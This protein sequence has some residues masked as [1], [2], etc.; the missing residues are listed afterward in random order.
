MH[1]VP[2]THDRAP[3]RA[4]DSLL[5]GPAGKLTTIDPIIDIWSSE[6]E[7]FNANMTLSHD[8]R[9]VL[10]DSLQPSINLE[11]ARQELCT[12]YIYLS[13][14]PSKGY[15]MFSLIPC[16]WQPLPSW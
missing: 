16:H 3:V 13:H 5:L 1:H 9:N 14:A 4:S 11:F 2:S 12:L 8:D 10:V 15:S 7:G 6:K